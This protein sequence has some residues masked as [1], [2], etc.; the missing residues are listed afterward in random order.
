MLTDNYK[1]MAVLTLNK[2]FK[3]NVANKSKLFTVDLTELDFIPTK[4]FLK[5]KYKISRQSDYYT[6][7]H[8]I[9][10]GE[11]PCFYANYF[12]NWDYEITIGQAKFNNKSL[13]FRMI[14]WCS[15]TDSPDTID[16]KLE[17]V[18]LIE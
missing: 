8:V 15:Q 18:I 13:E 1:K 5:F 12:L 11:T 7:Q 17:E 3:N 10:T 14:A 4:G 16:I 6:S 9:E 2:E